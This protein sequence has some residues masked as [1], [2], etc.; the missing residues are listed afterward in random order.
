MCFK[1]SVKREREREREREKITPQVCHQGSLNFRM[2]V[3][4]RRIIWRIWRNS[5]GIP[6]S[7]EKTLGQRK[8]IKR[9][10]S[11]CKTGSVNRILNVSSFI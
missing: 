6:S 2:G 5:E 3:R 9:P 4:S 1:A 11:C 7:E 8:A 10:K